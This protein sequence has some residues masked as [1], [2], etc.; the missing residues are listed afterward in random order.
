MEC[1]ICLDEK[2]PAEFLQFGCDH[3]TCNECFHAI[4]EKAKQGIGSL[5]GIPCCPLC[6]APIVTCKPYLVAQAENDT[7][8]PVFVL[9]ATFSKMLVLTKSDIRLR[10]WSGAFVGS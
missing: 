6:R 5:D 3:T 1:P 4:E 10:G 7:I 2:P 8:E 9:F